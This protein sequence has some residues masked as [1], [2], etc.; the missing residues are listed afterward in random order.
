MGKKG[1]RITVE[2]YS[3]DDKNFPLKAIETKIELRLR[4]AGIKV[5]DKFT[6]RSILIHTQPINAGGRVTGYAVSIKPIRIMEFTALDNTGKLVT[7][8]TSV[9]TI[10][11]YGGIAPD[12]RLIP[13]I[14]K[15]MDTLLVDYLKANPK[16]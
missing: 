1:V 14:D 8:E 3:K 13:F 2:D 6:G 11:T 7:Y 10:K 15:H 12:D 4:Q 16:R 5:S 9:S